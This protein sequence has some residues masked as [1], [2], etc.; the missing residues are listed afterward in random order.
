MRKTKFMILFLVLIILIVGI[1][2]NFNKES[3]AISSDIDPSTWYYVDG[4]GRSSTNDV[5]KSKKVRLVGMFYWTW[6]LDL[7]SPGPF[8]LNNI[9]KEHPDAK[10]DYNNST[11]KKYNAG[12]NGTGYYWWDEPLLGYY[13]ENDD[14]V[15]RKHAELLADAGV[16]FIVLDCTNGSFT[17]ESA[18]EN[19]LK[20]WK[21]ALEDGVK[22]PKV[23]FMFPFGYTADTSGV[24]FMNIYNNLYNPNSSNF[25]KYHS[26]LFDYNGK[27]LVLM[28]DYEKASDEIKNILKNFEVRKNYPAYFTS[29]A[30]ANG[31]WGWLSTYPQA[32]YKKANGEAEQISVGVSMNANYLTNTLTAM[33]GENIMGRS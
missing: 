5:T 2:L 21:E 24:S 17:W 26:L 16:D 12:A 19:L 3:Y 14:Y 32:Y 18:Y 15:L 20:V 8:N 1:F 10:N 23:A 4:L 27:Y 6:H 28:N 30:K 9:I 29:G 7:N 13:R 25:N 33:N 22:V 31:S 11:W